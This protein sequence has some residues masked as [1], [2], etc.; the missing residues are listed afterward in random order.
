[1]KAINSHIWRLQK[2]LLA[3][4]TVLFGLVLID[5]VATIFTGWQTVIDRRSIFLF[6]RHNE[7]LQFNSQQQPYIQ[8]VIFMIMLAINIWAKK[9][10]AATGFAN[11]SRSRIVYLPLV[12]IIVWLIGFFILLK[13]GL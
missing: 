10:K 8:G 11:G 13:G 9:Q 2:I 5:L 1:M 3:I 4:S 6:F 7:I 12:Y